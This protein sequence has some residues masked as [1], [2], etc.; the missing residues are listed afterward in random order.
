MAAQQRRKRPRDDAFETPV[1]TIQL[2][3][4]PPIIPA[5]PLTVE[6]ISSRLW[7]A[8]RGRGKDA[9]H[10][11]QFL[12]GMPWETDKERQE[13]RA[14]RFLGAGGHGAAAVWIKIDEK[15]N[16]LDEIVLKEQRNPSHHFLFQGF[17]QVSSEAVLHN[18][19]NVN[20]ECESE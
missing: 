1:Q 7:R 19:V 2:F 13:W 3:E 14:W 8:L 11:T 10:V 6:S 15:G 5:K 9:Y 4:N 17:P 18:M 12:R 20:D 16:L